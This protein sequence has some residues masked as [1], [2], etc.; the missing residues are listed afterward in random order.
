HRHAT[1][2]ARGEADTL[3]NLGVV[4]YRAGDTTAARRRYRESLALRR[5]LSDRHGIAMML[6]NLGELAELAGDVMTAVALFL[7]AERIF[8]ELQSAHVA[9]PADVLQRLAAQVGEPRW[10]ALRGAAERTTWEE[11]IQA[12]EV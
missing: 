12:G 6:N 10:E 11:V 7:H 4:A 3:A 2:D 8:R 1:G 9:A 5:R